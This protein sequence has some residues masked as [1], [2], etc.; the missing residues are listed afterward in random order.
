MVTVT[1]KIK[2]Y[3]KLLMVWEY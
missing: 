2:F 1:L 3:V